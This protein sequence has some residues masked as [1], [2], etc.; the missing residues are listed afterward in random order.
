MKWLPLFVHG[1]GPTKSIATLWKGWGTKGIGTITAWAGHRGWPFRQISQDLQY[2]ATVVTL[3][4][5]VLRLGDPKVSRRN[6]TNQHSLGSTSC[7]NLWPDQFDPRAASV[8][9]W[10]HPAGRNRHSPL[11]QGLQWPGPWFA[12]GPSIKDLVGSSCRNSLLLVGAVVQHVSKPV[13]LKT[14]LPML[15]SLVP[16]L[17]LWGP[18]TQLE[19]VPAYCLR[20][21]LSLKVGSP[22]Y[23]SPTIHSA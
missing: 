7:S 11:Q 13:T 18:W 15:V 21:G 22:L 16:P 12:T 1:K 5:A 19:E 9:P 4:D 8:G 23:L 10:A 2:L 14:F 17:P 3:E 20:E 6:N